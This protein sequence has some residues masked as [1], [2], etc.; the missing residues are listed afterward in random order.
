MKR[1]RLAPAVV[2][3]VAVAALVLARD[4]GVKRGPAFDALPDVLRAAAAALALFAVSGHGLAERFVPERLRPLRHLLMLPL[5]AMA[6]SLAFTALG[7]AHVPL[8]ASL[9]IVLAAGVVASVLVTRHAGGID[10]AVGA[11][12]GLGALLAGLV[13]VPS[14]RA[15][16]ATV[17]GL[18][19]DAQLVNG[20]AVLFQHAPPQGTRLGLPAPELPEVWRSKVPIFY[21]L[22][23]VARL[24]GL[25]PLAAFPTVAALLV[26]LVAAGFGLVGRVVLGLRSGW[27]VVAAAAAGL[28]VAL[29][30]VAVHPY[31]NQ[32]WGLLAFPFALA[33]AW[34]AV[35]EDDRRAL[36]LF[37]LALVLGGFA[38]PLMLPYPLVAFAA[39][40]LAERRLPGLPGRVRWP[41]VLAGVVVALAFAAPLLG[42]WEKVSSGVSNL[43]GGG[44]GLWS[45]DLRSFYGAGWFVGV[46]DGWAAAAA[47][48]AVAALGIAVSL[49]RRRAAALGG[50]L[51][52]CAL[53][54]VRL[55]L[56]DNGAYFDFK[57]LTFT[58]PLVLTAAVAGLA[59]LAARRRAMTAVAAAVLLGYAALAARQV[60]EELR[61]TYEQVTRPMLAL[62]DWSETIPAGR[63]L[64][65]DVAPSGYQLWAAYLLARHPLDSPVPIVRTTYP[66]VAPGYRADYA[67]SLAPA[68]EGQLAAS[69]LPPP[70]APGRLGAV[71]FANAQ[72]VVRRVLSAPGPATASRARY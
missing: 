1:G 31:W 60:D 51:A 26:G 11:Y 4:A 62:R 33:F 57:H 48:A 10:G 66:H 70:R 42:V 50:L 58:G 72:F 8:T 38:Y 9:A 27:A 40:G 39:F 71:V 37:V 63:S 69:G 15:G 30:H 18:N 54:D 19:P 32:L 29:M 25:D 56:A 7:F 2:A 16:F 67:V 24:S 65:L 53:A 49:P 5:G 43:V 6:S 68:L 55:R 14:F 22:A 35:V 36:A 17:P 64:R 20:L 3:V 21:A 28:D 41:W 52:L 61:G 23:A 34:L 44:G 45:G 13:L 59:W 46:G 47:V 12:V